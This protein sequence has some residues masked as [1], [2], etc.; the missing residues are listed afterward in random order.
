MGLHT[1]R[2]I[3]DYGSLA[4]SNALLQS[5]AILLSQFPY[6]SELEARELLQAAER[7]SHPAYSYVVLV[8]E[9]RHKQVL[10]LAI[11]SYFH[12]HNFYFL[13]YIA[14]RAQRISGGIGGAL[15]DRLRE[16]AVTTSATGIF[17]DCLSDERS[18]CENEE[19]WRQNAARLKFYERYGARPLEGTTYET[20]RNDRSVFHLVFDGLGVSRPLTVRSCRGIMKSIL[21]SKASKKCSLEYINKVMT[22]I[23]GPVTMRRP[24]YPVQTDRAAIPLRIPGDKKMALVVNEGHLIHHVRERGYL[25]SPIR[26]TTI[27]KELRKTTFFEH[28]ETKQFPEKLLEEVH[29]KAYLRFLKKICKLI[30]TSETRY[31]DVFP[32]RNPARL[33]KDIELQIGYYCIDTSTPL[34]ANAYIAARAAVNCALTAAEAVHEGKHFAYA[35]VRPPGH[36]AER[37]YFGGFCYLNSSAV[38]A[39]YLSKQGRVALLDIDYHH[40]NGQQEIF[41]HRADVFTVSIHG[42]PEYAYPNFT[43][44]ADEQGEAA[45]AGYNLNIPLPRSVGGRAYHK[46]LSL[47]LTAIRNYKPSSLVI[48]LGLDIAK[49]DP[50]G[51][52]TLTPDD[53]FQNGKLIASLHLPTVVVQEGG[54]KNKVLG[55]NARR[56]FEGLWEGYYGLQSKKK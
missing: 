53:F 14:T 36:H 45:G 2:R 41:Y 26:V 54:Y 23:K 31:G 12:A 35:L 55:T 19:E 21:E 24:R 48:A 38:A 13:D 47:A 27:L 29:D 42:D 8:A 43:G 15:Y 40:G 28:L 25:E 56:F 10:G 37:K 22:S 49:G 18:Q 17:F 44:F 33:P 51:T 6:L 9:G 52:W 39:Q 5:K 11:A 1:I 7:S 32:I 50:T 4:N 30:G 34:N 16:E 46:A 3:Y 20:P